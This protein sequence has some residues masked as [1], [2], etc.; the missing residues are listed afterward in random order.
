[1]SPS[2]LLAVDPRAC[3]SLIEGVYQERVNYI[4]ILPLPPSRPP[5]VRPLTS[6]DIPIAHS[7][8][9]DGQCFVLALR[10]RLQYFIRGNYFMAH[11]KPAT[12]QTIAEREQG[13]HW[14]CKRRDP[15]MD[16]GNA[17]QVEHDPS[18]RH[19]VVSRSHYIRSG[20]E[21]AGDAHLA[22]LHTSPAR[23]NP[24]IPTPRGPYEGQDKSRRRGPSWGSRS[25]STMEC[26]P[27][28][29]DPCFRSS[30]V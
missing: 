29:G 13:R 17:T 6:R 30:R 21:T 28:L 22:R 25:R 19:A 2:R 15:P 3:E 16:A 23:A 7:R 9:K 14:Q 18:N 24:C 10:L 20:L 11:Q 27:G 12:L 1:R 5:G 8:Y 4:S 26:R